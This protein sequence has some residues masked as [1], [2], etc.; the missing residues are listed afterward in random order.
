MTNDKALPTEKPGKRPAYGLWLASG[1]SLAAELCAGAGFDWLLIDGEHGPNDLRSILQQLQ[2]T[3]GFPVRTFVRPPTS[4]R[5]IINQLQDVGATRLLIPMVENKTQAEEIVGFTRYPQSGHRGVSGS[6]T[7]ASEWGRRS[8][9]LFKAAE[10][11]EIIVQ[12][13]STAGI[14]NLEE[15]IRVDGVD[16]VFLGPADLAASMGHL[17]EADHSAIRSVVSRGLHM[18]AE[19]GKVSGVFAS[20]PD[21]AKFYHSAGADMIAVG[22]DVGLLRKA[23]DELAAQYLSLG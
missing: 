6:L 5:V 15:I 23:A 17:G 8:D 10:E 11:T 3:R 19:Y 14:E 9:Y 1:D 22:S 21:S 12:V 7:R 13:E 16:G 20:G 4:D 2:A 18:I